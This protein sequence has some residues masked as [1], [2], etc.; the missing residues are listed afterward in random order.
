M[1][2]DAAGH[3]DLTEKIIGCGIRVHNELGPGLLES[4]YETCMVIELTVE[5]FCVERGRR[6]PVR[7]RGQLLDDVLIPDLIVEKTVVIEIKSVDRFHPVHKAQLITYLSL[8]N[9]PIG[10]LMNFGAETLKAGLKRV[11]RPDLYR[12]FQRDRAQA[13]G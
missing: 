8:S 5:G 13:N 4:V 12:K 7:Y 2:H 9:C 10:L 1:F 6:V 3:E 11:V